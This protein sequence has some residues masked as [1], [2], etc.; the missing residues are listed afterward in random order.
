MDLFDILVQHTFEEN[1]GLESIEFI[2]RGRGWQEVHNFSG[3][4]GI[5]LVGNPLKPYFKCALNN[6]SVGFLDPANVRRVEYCNDG[7]SSTYG[8][9]GSAVHRIPLEQR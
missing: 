9:P 7:S 4:N 1:P 3:E 6:E 8:P 2:K 5:S